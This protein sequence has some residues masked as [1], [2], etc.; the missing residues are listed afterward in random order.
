MPG[1]NISRRM[2]SSSSPHFVIFPFMAYGHTIPLLHLARLLR[3]KQVSVTIFTTPGN[4]PSIRTFLQDL[5]VSII[6]LLFPQVIEGIPPGVENTEKL[7]S[8]S[9]FLQFA[10]S[11]KLMQPNFEAALETILPVNCI[12][13]DAFLGWTQQS[14]KKRGIP[15]LLFYGMSIFAMTMYQIM[16]REKPHSG[17][18]SFDQPFKI[19][20]FPSWELT[21]NDF[22][23]PFCDPEP[24]GPYIDFMVEQLEFMFESHGLIVNTFY[25]LERGYTDYWNK[26]IGPKAWCIGPLCLAR[27]LT[28]PRSVLELPWYMKWLDHKSSR[29][30]KVLYVAFGTQAQLTS[31][32]FQEIAFGLETSGM[33]FLWVLRSNELDW[34]Q[35]FEDRVKNR[36]MVV[37]EWVDQVEILSH[38]SIKG[39]LSHCG[40]NSVLESICA[41]VP[42]LALPLMA[43]QHLNARMVVEEMGVGLRIMPEGGGFRGLVK[44]GEVEKMVRELMNGNEDDEVMKRAK[45]LS[46]AAFRAMDSEDGSSM[47]TLNLLITDVSGNN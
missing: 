10:T 35:G 12:V 24:T 39:F 25:E 29:G 26:I 36:G 20:G 6:E 9:S 38:V 1:E 43:E 31:E 32:Q 34:V 21:R 40:W 23:P 2:E 44:S 5:D 45:E 4:S 3:Q 42:I 46:Q 28:S 15:R 47:L 37:K 11:T 27:P 16:G 41:G 14:A 30:E 18:I 17:I 22:D 13:S 33:N 8:I 7:P 19:P